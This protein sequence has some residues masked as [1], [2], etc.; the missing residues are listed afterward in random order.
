MLKI[1]VVIIALMILYVLWRLYGKNKTNI[2]FQAQNHEL[3]QMSHLERDDLDLPEKT[4]L[5]KQIHDE[6][7]QKTLAETVV[8]DNIDALNQNLEISV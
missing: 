8:S 4:K 3:A 2:A 5:I 7:R 6:Q 1:I